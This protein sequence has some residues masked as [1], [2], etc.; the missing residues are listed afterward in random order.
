MTTKPVLQSP[1]TA[2]AEPAHKR[3]HRKEKQRE[4]SS[5]LPQL[6]KCLRGTEDPAQPKINTEI[7]IL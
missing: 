2:A 5:F 4:S 7:K 6:E 1:G 3:S